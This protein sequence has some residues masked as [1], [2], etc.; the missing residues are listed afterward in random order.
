[1]TLG[2]REILDDRDIDILLIGSTQNVPPCLSPKSTDGGRRREAVDIEILIEPR[3]DAATHRAKHCIPP[4]PSARACT[5]AV[6]LVSTENGVPLCTV[7]TLA[8]SQ[9]LAACFSKNASRPCRNWASRK[10]R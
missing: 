5:N 2:N 6:A 4:P 8:S 1:M 10:Y 3:F 7:I 9:P